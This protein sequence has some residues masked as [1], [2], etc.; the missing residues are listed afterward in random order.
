VDYYVFWENKRAA[1]PES[2]VV[3]FYRASWLLVLTLCCG[4]FELLDTQAIL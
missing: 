2:P 3:L 4:I 1:T